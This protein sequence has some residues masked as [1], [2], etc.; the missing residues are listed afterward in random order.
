MN[1]KR[2]YVPLFPSN[3][4][5]LNR[6]YQDIQNQISA[7]D[8]ELNL[9]PK[10]KGLTLEFTPPG[11][12]QSQNANL[13]HERAE[14]LNKQRPEIL[15]NY[16]SVV[17]K[18]IEVLDPTQQKDI[19]DRYDF[20]TSSNSFKGQPKI[21]LDSQKGLDKDS[22]KSFDFMAANHF[23]NY[24]QPGNVEANEK[25]NIDEWSKNF[26]AMLESRGEQE[27]VGKNQDDLD[28]DKE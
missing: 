11:L 12:K 20:E 16:R 6:S 5:H 28:I 21:E 24:Q 17:A 1:E 27:V 14:Y 22:G 3:F 26:N 8:Q 25:Q 9:A 2:K 15:K 7:I 18:E 23:A 4:D 13:R 19:L 10:D